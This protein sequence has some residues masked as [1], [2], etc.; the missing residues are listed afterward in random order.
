MSTMRLSTYTQSYQPKCTRSSPRL[1]P[2]CPSSSMVPLLGPLR[3]RLIETVL[4]TGIPSY[5]LT[6]VLTSKNAIK[7]LSIK[8]GEYSGQF[9]NAAEA[10]AKLKC[11]WKEYWAAKKIA[12]ALRLTY[13]EEL[14]SRK[15]ADR[16]V[17]TEQLTKIMIREEQSRQEGRDSKQIR[18]RNT[19]S[20]VLKAEVM[21]FITSTTRIVETQEEI[22]AAAAESNLR[23]QSQ[24]MGTASAYLL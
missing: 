19:K 14:M 17:T 18:G 13:Q 23:H 16:K 10:L 9:L 4:T 3:Y 11:A 2:S 22:V 20:P 21:D 24:T 7:R 15:A 8:I 5:E 12:N 1:T 6:G